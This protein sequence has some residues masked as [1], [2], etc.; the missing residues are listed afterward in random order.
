MFDYE[1]SMFY[2]HVIE[3]LKESGHVFSSSPVYT[4][5][6]PQEVMYDDTDCGVDV[7]LNRAEREAVAQTSCISFL[8][9]LCHDAEQPDE[10]I[11]VYSYTIR[12]LSTV[13]SELA[14]RSHA[15]LHQFWGCSYSLAFV[16]HNGSFILSMC[17]SYGREYLSDWYQ[18]DD[19]LDFVDRMDIATISLQS[20]KD[21][22][23]DIVYATARWYYLTPISAEYGS[24]EL[25]PTTAL[26]DSFEKDPMDID[27]EEIKQTV[28]DTIYAAEKEY[29]DDY[30]EPHELPH[31]SGFD[32]SAEIDMLGFE[33]DLEEEGF[34]DVVDDFDD[35]SD[36]EHHDEYEFED[37]DQDLFDDPVR[38]VKWLEQNT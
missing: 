30:V 32:L 36:E 13:R 7:F 34:S 16:H 26:A 11:G 5:H 10:R 1:E 22:F 25:F 15:A 6:D 3:M 21:Y 38:L 14:A 8:I 37:L 17:D 24:Y 23:Y 18:V 19:I 33:L 12:A 9:S 20:T 4:N 31:T 2:T 28:R 35:E 27:R 29:G